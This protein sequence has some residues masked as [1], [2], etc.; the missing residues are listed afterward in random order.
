MS[1]DV[2]EVKKL[3]QKIEEAEAHLAALRAQWDAL[4]VGGD[5][6]E[7]QN[8]ELAFQSE[9]NDDSDHSYGMKTERIMQVLIQNPSREFGIRELSTITGLEELSVGRTLYRQAQAGKIRQLRRG[10]YAYVGN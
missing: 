6:S 1:P 5:K 3:V 2:K 4:F 10:I 7:P 9:D 8:I